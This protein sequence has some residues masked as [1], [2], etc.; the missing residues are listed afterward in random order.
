VVLARRRAAKLNRT[1]AWADKGKIAEVY[2]L[3]KFSEEL[4]LQTHHVDHI[5]PLRGKRVSGL[6]VHTN[7]QVLP[8]LL[9]AHKGRKFAPYAE[10][11]A[12][13]YAVALIS[14]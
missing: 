1:P 3:A 14:A 7:L 10:H 8:G 9:N 5:V 13:G 11:Y 2:A 12:P 6:H 4:T